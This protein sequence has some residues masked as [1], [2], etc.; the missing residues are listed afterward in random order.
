MKVQDE[1]TKGKTQ[2]PW[3]SLK[4]NWEEESYDVNQASQQHEIFQNQMSQVTDSTI[5]INVKITNSAK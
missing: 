4:E 1:V 2:L 3:D 5:H